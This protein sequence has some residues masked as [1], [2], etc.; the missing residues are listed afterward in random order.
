MVA[1]HVMTKLNNVD[2]DA[3]VTCAGYFRKHSPVGCTI[4]KA[5]VADTGEVISFRRHR[6]DTWFCNT[7]EVNDR[8]A[9]L[10]Q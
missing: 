6:G 9:P 2:N 1:M 8:W 3:T 4:D 7:D 5:T 10:V